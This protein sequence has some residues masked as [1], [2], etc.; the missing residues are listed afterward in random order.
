MSIVPFRSP[1]YVAKVFKS[2]PFTASGTLCGCVDFTDGV[3]TWCMTVP[4]LDALV[5][6]LEYA[7]A[8]VVKNS[9]PF[10]DPRIVR[11]QE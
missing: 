10:T 8:D 3:R 11:L 2:G 6:M 5:A 9:R 1:E 7:R 4:E